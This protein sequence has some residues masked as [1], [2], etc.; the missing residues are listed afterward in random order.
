MEPARKRAKVVTPGG[1]VRPVGPLP[2]TPSGPPGAL[3]GE[4]EGVIVFGYWRHR[5]LAQAARLLLA[6]SGHPWVDHRY[7][8]GEVSYP[9]LVIITIF[10]QPPD[11]RSLPSGGDGTALFRGS[12]SL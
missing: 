8:V 11:C 10:P 2:A 7:E 1:E 3:A 9:L 6:H 12:S 4:E 5:I